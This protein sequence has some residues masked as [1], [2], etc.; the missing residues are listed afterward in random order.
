[1]SVDTEPEIKHG[2]SA[3]RQGCRCAVCRKA[4]SGAESRRR[5]EPDAPLVSKLEFD[6]SCF[7]CGAE[8]HHENSSRPT[9]V[10]TRSTAVLRCSS[11]RRRWMI[12]LTGHPFDGEA[13]LR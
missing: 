6:V 1:M 5:A 12:L 11:C 10:G 9:E 3:Y 13:P 4:K 7:Y 8:V 2:I